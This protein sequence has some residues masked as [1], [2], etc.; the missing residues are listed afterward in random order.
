[1]I[2]VLY[3]NIAAQQF[4]GATYSLMNLITSVKGQVYPIVL[5]PSKGCV[6]DFFTRG[7]G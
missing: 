5:L 6:Y 1:M 2:N 4:D 3:V 7:G